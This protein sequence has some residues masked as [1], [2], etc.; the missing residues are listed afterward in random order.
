M[1]GWADLDGWLYIE[2]VYLSADSQKSFLVVTSNRLIATQ[3]Q[4]KPTACIVS[5]F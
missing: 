1:E 4:I 3:L 5:T 2:M